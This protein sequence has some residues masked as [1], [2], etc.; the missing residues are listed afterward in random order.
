M[1]LW[2]SF[3]F[4]VGTQYGIFLCRR[5]TWFLK[6][7]SEYQVK[8]QDRADYTSLHIPPCTSCHDN[9]RLPPDFHACITGTITYWS[10]PTSAH[11][12][13][14]RTRDGLYGSFPPK[15]FY[16]RMWSSSKHSALSRD[17]FKCI[18]LLKP[19]SNLT[20]T[21]LR[22]GASTTSLSNQPL[23]LFYHLI[24][25]I[26]HFF[27]ISSLPYIYPLLVQNHYPCPFA[28]GPTDRFVPIFLVTLF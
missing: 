22:D 1:G 23:P 9:T 13:E 6:N 20:L 27:L 12:S 3:L 2:S 18:R 7:I 14:V 21:V 17:I 25:I 10:I 26:T 5:C 24:L 15:A 28:T 4:F 8:E 19:W 16:D 11:D